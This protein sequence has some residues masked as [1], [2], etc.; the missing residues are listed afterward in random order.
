MLRRLISVFRSSDPLREMGENF[1]EMLGIAQ[2]L[3]L[4]AGKIF[5]AGKE[6]PDE[7]TWIYDQDVRVNQLERQIRKQVIAH[8][9]LSGQTLDLPYC[10]LLI[11]LVK[12]VE[13]IGDY[14]KN[15]TEIGDFYTGPLPDDELVAELGEIRNGVESTFKGL[16]QL[17]G[18]SDEE[19]ALVL[20]QQGKE[21]LRRCD[22][23]IARAAQSSLD[24]AATVA[25]VLGTRYYKRIGGHVLNI[26]S[27]VVMPLHKVDYYD[28]VSLP[29]ELKTRG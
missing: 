23:L 28:E 9:S 2:E 21:L 17:L 22:S 4:R 19:A 18:R 25:V 6:A 29:P 7:R 5:F 20:I 16:A 1:A 27:S 15:L 8:L 10:L 24:A 14:S 26:L 11:S 3:S 12:D 13:R